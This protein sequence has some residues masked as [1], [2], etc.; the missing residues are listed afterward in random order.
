LKTYRRLLLCLLGSDYNIACLVG[1]KGGRT[2]PNN[3]KGLSLLY[4]VRD[5]TVGSKPYVEPFGGNELRI[6]F[7]EAPYDVEDFVKVYVNQLPPIAHYTDQIMACIDGL[8]VEN[9]NA[10]LKDLCAAPIPQVGETAGDASGDTL[11]VPANAAVPV[12]VLDS[13]ASS[14]DHMPISVETGGISPMGLSKVGVFYDAKTL[15][16]QYAPVS[17]M[18]L[19]LDQV[20]GTKIFEVFANPWASGTNIS[21][22]MTSWANL[23]EFYTGTIHYKFKVDGT[24][25][26][27][28]RILVGAVPY[29]DNSVTFTAAQLK[30]LGWVEMDISQTSSMELSIKPHHDFYDVISQTASIDKNYGRIV[31]IAYTTFNNRYGD[32]GILNF[33]IEAKFGVDTIFTGMGSAVPLQGPTRS[34][35]TFVPLQ[36]GLIQEHFLCIDGKSSYDPICYARN[37]NK[38]ARAVDLGQDRI[39]MQKETFTKLQ[40]RDTD[41]EAPKDA[42]IKMLLFSLSGLASEQDFKT[43]N[44][45]AGHTYR[46]TL[47]SKDFPRATAEEKSILERVL[48]VRGSP[49]VSASIGPSSSTEPSPIEFSWHEIS[50]VEPFNVFELPDNVN[51]ANYLV[52]QSLGSFTASSSMS[53]QTPLNRNAGF[54]SKG[55]IDEYGQL[56]ELGWYKSDHSGPY[57]GLPADVK[58]L[59]YPF[60]VVPQTSLYTGMLHDDPLE[61]TMVTYFTRNGPA[62]ANLSPGWA[63]INFS[64]NPPGVGDFASTQG[65]RSIPLDEG[66]SAF[67]NAL[68]DLCPITGAITFDFSTPNAGRVISLKFTRTEGLV[69]RLPEGSKHSYAFCPTLLGNL[70][71]TNFNVQ[72]T[73]SSTVPVT[74]FSAWNTRVIPDYILLNKGVAEERINNDRYRR[75]YMIKAIEEQGFVPENSEEGELDILDGLS[76]ADFER[77]P[78]VAQMAMA[79]AMIGGSALQGIGGGVAAFAQMKQSEKMF[80]RE[81][82][83][84]ISHDTKMQANLQAHQSFMQ[85]QNIENQ[86]NMQYASHLNQHALQHNSYLYKGMMVNSPTSSGLERNSRRVEMTAPAAAAGNTSFLYPGTPDLHPWA[87][88]ENLTSESFA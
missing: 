27:T 57:T 40:W 38:R 11:T 73:S 1:V 81:W 35:G 74:D 71:V 34:L 80:D 53:Y 79:A 22:A 32:S 39:G 4:E 26:F 8:I 47:R 43:M 31:G 19:S 28:G 58:P 5:L 83:N 14:N 84:R 30:R 67:T 16:Y 21:P 87:A 55:E 23:H 9:P 70:V 52:K 51:K 42:D 88:Q 86:R 10:Q 76:L 60:A 66:A 3:P 13:T 72:T 36:T 78:P 48:D 7:E 49:I 17:T 62:A 33:T 6:S 64:R 37:Y 63:R 2:V 50:T 44:L 82:Q 20:A 59:T 69:A 24:A 41:G 12:A 77:N 18:Q 15:A 29:N 75:Y 68:Y 46:S 54:C 61:P 85:S 45:R 65:G 56:I 25:G